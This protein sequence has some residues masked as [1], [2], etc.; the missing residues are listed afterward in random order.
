M[1]FPRVIVASND[2]TEDLHSSE[3]TCNY[4]VAYIEGGRRGPPVIFSGLKSLLET[5]RPMPKFDWS[6]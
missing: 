2:N 6:A 3:L 4:Y 1:R 5:S